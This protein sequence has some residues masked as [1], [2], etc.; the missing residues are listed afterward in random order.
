MTKF[1]N[2]IF[3]RLPKK[4]FMRLAPLMTF[5]TDVIL[6]YYI[7]KVLLPLLLSDS[8]LSKLL[9]EYNLVPADQIRFLDLNTVRAGLYSSTSFALTIAILFNGLIYLL[10]IKEMKWAL[11]YVKGYA[12]SAA[13]LS[14]AELFIYF[15]TLRF[16][17][18]Y[19]FFTMLLYFLVYYGYRYFSK[20]EVKE[21]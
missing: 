9:L 17:N 2:Q 15:F 18:F 12:F 6:I 21:N 16:F 13:I 5:F 4:V 7:N 8:N 20:I 19:T 11:R 10:A 14:I 1:L 3:S